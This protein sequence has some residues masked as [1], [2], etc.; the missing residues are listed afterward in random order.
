MHIKFTSCLIPRI[1]GTVTRGSA[2][3]RGVYGRVRRHFRFDA[4]VAMNGGGMTLSD[5]IQCVVFQLAET[6]FAIDI[7]VVNEIIVRPAITP[8]PQAPAWVE[9]IA[10]L[11]GRVMPVIDMRKRLQLPD[12]TEATHA[13][14]LTLDSDLVGML[15]EGVSEVLRIPMAEVV[16][17]PAE[18]QASHEGLITG[19]YTWREHFVLLWDSSRLRGTS[20]QAGLLTTRAAF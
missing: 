2:L 15:V 11:R 4:K 18:I 17:P 10:N 5:E 13:L 9:G 6:L 1:I 16:P 8:I 7:Q 3:D 14:V 20:D 19:I 12:R